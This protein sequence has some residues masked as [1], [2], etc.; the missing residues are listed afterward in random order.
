MN[1]PAPDNTPEAILHRAKADLLEQVRQ[2]DF[3]IRRLDAGGKPTMRKASGQRMSR[4][5]RKIQILDLLRA[6]PAREFSPAELRTEYGLPA[7]SSQKA[8]ADL[9]RQGK[10]TVTAQKTRNG[11]PYVQ[12][13]ATAIR[14]GE[15]VEAS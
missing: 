6:E 14:P 4:W 5:Q 15:N 9:I 10:V 1:A 3:A 7:A 11:H 8:I 13:K 2:I 12:H